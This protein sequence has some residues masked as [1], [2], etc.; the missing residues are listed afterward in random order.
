MGLI[1]VL[2]QE[3][4]NH[5]AAGEV[6]DRPQSV[7]KELLENSIDSG[8]KRI[9]IDIEN[10]GLDMIRITDDG[11]GFYK[12][13]IKVAFLRHATSKIKSFED[14]VSVGSLGFRGE[15]LSSIAAVCQVNLVTK[16]T[17]DT[18]GSQY[19]IEGGSEKTFED[20]GAQDGTTITVRNI[21]YNTPARR[22]FLKS[23]STE[24]GYIY[25]IVEKIALSNPD[26]SFALNSN[27]REKLRTPGN[28]SLKDTIYAI[29]GRDISSNLIEFHCENSFVK[30]N[31]FLG[32]PVITRGN[33]NYENY[34]IN[35]R[36]IKNDIITKAIEEGYKTFMMQ[37]MY[38]FTLLMIDIDKDLLDVNV[39]PS[40]MELRIKRKEEIFD[41]L[42]E[43]IKD[44]LKTSDLIREATIIGERVKTEEDFGIKKSSNYSSFINESFDKK[45][46]DVPQ[47]N[48]ENNKQDIIKQEIVN[49]E[50]VKPIDTKPIDAKPIE[51]KPIETKPVEYKQES[52][53]S[54]NIRNKETKPDFKIVGQVFDTYWIVEYKE[55]MYIIDQHAAH[56]KV[57]Y[58][59]YIKM[60]NETGVN[61]QFLSP[62]LVITLTGSEQETVKK[63]M[64]TL[65]KFGYELEPFGLKEYMV[66]S[67]PY[68][69]CSQNYADV[70]MEIIA[71]LENEINNKNTDIINDRIATMSCK[72]A[73]KGN[74][75]ISLNEAK[76]LISKLLTLEN[77]FNCPHG[78]PTIIEIT[79]YEMEKKF[80]RIV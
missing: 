80:K 36:F 29:Y 63:Y 62:P 54:P 44:A 21:F 51:T 27:G 61:K 1:N 17:E 77:P 25:D 47:K 19:V 4:I 20:C 52:F 39:H 41:L 56:E 74:Q 26:I 6:V 30:I 48:F 13:D 66:R 22:K 11:C 73:I 78:R 57:N 42:S 60:F 10:G 3:T 16:R 34:Y 68:N 64:D 2:D 70:L 24:G 8:A 9:T 69:L 18:F 5:I 67:V 12:D 79:K 28:G 72:A 59:N 32:K 37:H 71:S 38:P 14:L 75:A 58:E 46:N 53:I 40:K 65:D 45:Y 49:Q 55:S 76:E 35:S 15:A 33:R 43:N 23:G 31:G 50:I 7:V